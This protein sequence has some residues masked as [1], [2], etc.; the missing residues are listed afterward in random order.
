MEINATKLAQLLDVAQK[1]IEVDSLEA[2]L[3]TEKLDLS[4]AYDD[5]KERV[6]INYIAADTPEWTE[7]LASTKGEYAAV[8]E[9][10]RNLKNARSRLKS[11]IRRYRA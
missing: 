10:K 8:E 11:A 5:H 4:T 7:M 1:A 3:A 2:V 9:A 6:G